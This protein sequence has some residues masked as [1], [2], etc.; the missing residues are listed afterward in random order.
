MRDVGRKFFRYLFTGGLASVIDTSIF[1]LLVGAHVGIV[2]ASVASFGVAALANY[3]MASRFVFK[4]V[5]SVR[6]FLIF[7]AVAL[8]GLTV[9]TGVT[10][11]CVEVLALPPVLGKIGGIGVAFLINFTLNLLFVFRQ[12][13]RRP[14]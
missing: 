3:L 2:A 11:F 7:V 5:A 8:V 12:P 14:E 10:V 13:A 1:A 9:N 6:G 4:R